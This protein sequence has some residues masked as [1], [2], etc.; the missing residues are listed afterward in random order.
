MFADIRLLALV[1]VHRGVIR[2][3]DDATSVG[4]DLAESLIG[5]RGAQLAGVAPA[6]PLQGA[7]ALLLRVVPG[8]GR[9]ALS[10]FELRIAVAHPEILAAPSGGGEGEPFRTQAAEA[11]LGVAAGAQGT[12]LWLL[13]T[14]VN[15]F[16]LVILQAVA[17]RTDAAVG[18][19]QVL[20][21]A[22]GTFLRVEETFI[23]IHTGPAIR[24]DLVAFIAL[25]LE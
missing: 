1:H 24:S 12:D 22:W 3:H 21:G 20:A 13:D 16:A 6:F 9:G 10:S 18:P 7:T 11:A 8:F 5:L 19:I 15:I 25:A 2:S 23:D 14:L 4:T 17:G